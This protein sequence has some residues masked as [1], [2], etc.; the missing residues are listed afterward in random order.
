[1]IVYNVTTKVDWSVANN[2]VQWMKET[3]IPGILATG[4]FSNFAFYRLLQVDDEDGQTFTVQY[5]ADDENAYNDYIN[6]HA[7][8]FRQEVLNRY[9]NKLIA[10]RSLM[11]EVE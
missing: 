11:E 4:C 9:G 3:H 2:W 7:A 1:M 8:Y 5:F 6:Q 10:F